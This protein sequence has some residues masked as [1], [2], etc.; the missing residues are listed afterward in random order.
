MGFD[1]INLYLEVPV[2]YLPTVCLAE[3]SIHNLLFYFIDWPVVTILN[4]LVGGLIEFK[5]SRWFETN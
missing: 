5:F 1:F 2:R 4:L 3:K